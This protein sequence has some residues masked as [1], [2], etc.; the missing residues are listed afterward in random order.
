MIFRD[1]DLQLSMAFFHLYTYER[2]G[3]ISRAYQMAA[4]NHI[5]SIEKRG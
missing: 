4:K 3:M 1:P 2:A 5:W